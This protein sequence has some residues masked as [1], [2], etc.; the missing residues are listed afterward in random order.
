MTASED[1]L[2]H[3]TFFANAAPRIMLTGRSTP[4]VSITGTFDPASP[5]PSEKMVR[6][7]TRTITPWGSADGKNAQMRVTLNVHEDAIASLV[8]VRE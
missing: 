7:Q 4:L 2:F 3:V 6:F 8:E 1:R 5:E